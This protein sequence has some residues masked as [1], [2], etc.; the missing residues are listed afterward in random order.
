MDDDPQRDSTEFLRAFGRWLRLL[1]HAREMSQEQLGTRSGIDRAIIGRIERGE[2][3]IGIAY[4]PP[5]ADAL[6]IHV[7]DLF[8]IDR[9]PLLNPDTGAGG[10][11]G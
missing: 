3:N 11:P 7:H 10:E 5:L 1:R 2:V 6:G 8:P 4:L 9:S